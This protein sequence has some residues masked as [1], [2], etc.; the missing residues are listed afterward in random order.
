[1]KLIVKL[2]S[3]ALLSLGLSVISAANHEAANHEHMLTID[4]PWAPH[5]GKRTMSAAVYLSLH[6]GGNASDSLIDV[7]SD[8]AGMT[9][10]HQS[11][12]EDGIMRMDHVNAL[13]VPAGGSAALAPGGYHIMLMQLHAPL[14]KGEYFP[15]TL[16]FEKAGEVTVQVEITGIGGPE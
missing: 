5:T 11:Y 2:L 8:V 10:L 3:A 16:V 9:M 1:M 15:L 6:N 7:K 13:E 14:K 12:E 4:Q